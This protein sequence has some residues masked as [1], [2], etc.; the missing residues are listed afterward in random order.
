MQLGSRLV[1]A[2]VRTWSMAIILFQSPFRM[3]SLEAMKGR[4]GEY[5]WIDRNGN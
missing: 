3:L 4:E 2:D 1:M 5:E